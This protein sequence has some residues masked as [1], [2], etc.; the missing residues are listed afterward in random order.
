MIIG[1]AVRNESYR[2][3]KNAALSKETPKQHDFERNQ[4]GSA[5]G[6]ECDMAKRMLKDVENKNISVETIVMYNDTMKIARA[7]NKVKASRK[8][9][10]NGILVIIFPEAC[11]TRDNLVT[12]I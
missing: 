2:F 4:D 3:C 5:K 10:S 6:L 7:R 1:Y 9:K 8:T 12:L 11:R